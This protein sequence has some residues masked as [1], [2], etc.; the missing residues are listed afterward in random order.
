M[1]RDVKIDDVM[2]HAFVDHE[3]DPRAVAEVEEWLRNN[4]TDAARVGAWQR[5]ARDLAQRFDAILDEPLPPQ[6]LTTINRTAAPRRWA[7]QAIAASLLLATGAFGGWYL[8]PRAPAPT[9]AIETLAAQAQSAYTVFVSEVRHPVEV[10]VVEKEHLIAWLSKRLGQPLMAPDLSGTGFALMGGR[11]LAQDNNPAAQFMYENA[12]GQRITL[13]VAINPGGKETAFRIVNTA[14][15]KSFYW[16]DGP[17]GFAI[18]GDVVQGDLL[19]IA[20]AAYEQL[21]LP[22]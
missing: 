14:T 13:Y 7:A 11:L 16:L 21:A 2:L 3:L 8:A 17:L 18:T 1:T 5:Q 20:R 19:D 6:W 4:P 15:T 10:T 22:S 9:E 12:A